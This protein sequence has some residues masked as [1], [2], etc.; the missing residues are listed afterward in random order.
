MS[1]SPAVVPELDVT[2]LDASLDF[3]VNVCGFFA[4]SERGWLMGQLSICRRREL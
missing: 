3:Y 1:N 4:R 2:N